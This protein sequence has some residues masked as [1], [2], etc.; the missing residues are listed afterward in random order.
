[1]I[2]QY[3]IF[4]FDGDLFPLAYKLIEE[5]KEVITCQI[6]N[7]AILGTDTWISQ[8]EEPERRRRRL[9]LYDGMLDKLS[10]AQTITK[11]EKIK[12]K[13]GCFVIFGHNSLCNIADHIKKLGFKNGLMPTKED[14]LREQNRED[15]KKFVKKYYPELKVAETKEFSNVNEVIKFVEESDKFWVVKSDGNHGETIVPDRD[16]LE[17]SKQQIRSELTAS[18]NAYNKGKLILEQKIM[19]VKE[20]APQMVWY[21]GEPVYSEIE[22]ES[23]MFGAGDIGD[24]TG[25][26]QNIVIRSELDDKINEMAF[27]PII[28]D[29][30]KKHKGMYIADAGILSDGKDFYF[31]EFAGNR[32]G[33][34]GIFSELSACKNKKAMADNYFESIIEGK[35]PYKFDYGTSLAVY[36][37]RS[38]AKVPDMNEEGLSLF[39]KD[40]VKDDFFIMQCKKS[41]E[42]LV[43]VGYREFDSE[44]LGYVVGRGNSVEEAI[45]SIYK[46][47]KGISMKG[48]YYRPE[49]DWLTTSYSSSVMSRI[50]FLKEKKLI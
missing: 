27:P 6:K 35:E 26:N 5:G 29:I 23:R 43:N 12:D 14:Y 46:T 42:G 22:I 44:P 40:S 18:A 9:S 1:M 31:T 7:P 37:I 30:A 33:F 2:N 45:K 49:E 16:D 41:K 3:A 36:S 25:G 47:L 21:N 39:V 20:F 11:M 38:D 17:L 10:L 13:D 19:N 8:K 4:T 32:W 28:Y 15:A 50:D 48:L 24:Q 34:G